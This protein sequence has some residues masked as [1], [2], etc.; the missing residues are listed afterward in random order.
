MSTRR[1]IGAARIVAA[2]I[3]GYGVIVFLTTVGF[4]YWLEN[5]NLY[6]GGWPLKAKGMLVALVAGLAGGA[7]AA[8]IGGRRPLL[9][10]VA[11]L[12]LLVIDTTYV[13]FFFPRTDPLWFDLGGG[14]SLM[15]ATIGGG[16]LVRALRPPPTSP[17]APHA[18][19]SPSPE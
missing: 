4:V 16:F 9:H 19:A 6:R 5:A 13:L 17:F 11:V 3:L 14:L 18:P 1:W 8:L 15:A 10:A 12:P 7:L 2:A